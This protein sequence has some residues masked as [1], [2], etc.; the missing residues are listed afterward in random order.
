MIRKVRGLALAL[1]ALLAMSGLTASS[2]SAHNVV[3]TNGT[4]PQHLVTEDIGQPDV[5]TINDSQLTCVEESGTGTLN[6]PSTVWETTFL[7]QTCST[8]GAGFHNMTVTH[9]GCVFK[10]IWKEHV[11]KHWD[12]GTGQLTCPEGKVGE[13]HHYSSAHNKLTGIASCTNTVGS[14]VFVGTLNVT[15]LTTSGDM[16]AHGQVNF[17]VQTHGACTFGFTLNQTATLDASTTGR[18]TSGEPIHME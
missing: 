18:A 7:F 3:S 6:G 15:S 8:V 9:N 16:E 12:R 2:S 1:V 4:Y 5:I 11:E 10:T 17:T 14:Q 13:I